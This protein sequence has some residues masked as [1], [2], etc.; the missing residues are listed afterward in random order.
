MAAARGE[1]G[2]LVVWRPAIEHTIA[3]SGVRKRCRTLSGHNVV[4]EKDSKSG[5]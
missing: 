5:V 4:E 1:V 3:V 2:V